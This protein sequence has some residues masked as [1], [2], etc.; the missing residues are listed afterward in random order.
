MMKLF[1]GAPDN[2]EDYTV[3][4]EHAA[5]ALYS[6]VKS[7]MHAICS[8]AE[9][10]LHDAALWHIQIAKPGAISRWSA[11]ILAH[12][13]PP[14]WILN[15]NAHL[16]DIGWSVEMQMKMLTLVERYMSWGAS[17]VWRVPR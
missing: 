2:P 5:E 9:E 8:E 14:V 10:A 4:E 17:D 15:K 7:L 11:L 1:S 12:G 3:M 16:I 6:T 13:K